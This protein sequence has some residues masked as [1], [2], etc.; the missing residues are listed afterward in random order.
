MSEN[1]AE[2]LKKIS[3]KTIMGGKVKA[4]EK[5]TDLYTVYGVAT[6]TRTGETDKGPW[7]SFTGSFE[8]V[9]LSDN[10]KFVSPQ[11][12]LPEPM[13]GMLL[14]T[15]D[16]DASV[17]FAVVIG[18]KPSDSPVGYEYTVRPLVKPQ[19]ND[20]VAQLRSQVVG[21]LEAPKDSKK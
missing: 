11:V 4:P 20:A 14:S 2:M 17:E 9:R 13:Q 16:G 5:Q 15:L 19:E 1:Q 6:G 21:T 3:A 7:V 12:F 18:N 10:A 8:A